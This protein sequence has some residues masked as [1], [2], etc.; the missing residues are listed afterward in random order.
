V[1]HK[2]ISKSVFNDVREIT[3]FEN[4]HKVAMPQGVFKGKL[5]APIRNA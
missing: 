2:N 1:K 3:N 5:H 4:L